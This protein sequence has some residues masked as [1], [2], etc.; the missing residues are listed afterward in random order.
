M[1]DLFEKKE[2]GVPAK[3]HHS[4]V[5]VVPPEE[6]WGPIQA[7]RE[8]HDRQFMRWMPHVNLLYPFYPPGC[9]EEAMPRLTDACAGNIPFEVQLA[10]FGYFSHP[11]GKATL[12]LAPEPREAIIRLQAALQAACPECDDL[13]RFSNGFT[14]HLSVGQ[15]GSVVEA[16]K[17]LDALQEDWQPVRFVLSAVALLRRGQDTPFEISGWIPRSI[18]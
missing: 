13:S 15:A 17:L 2:P 10:E 4:A 9:F 8:E 7:I 18:N 12:W 6:A 16:Q 5:A 14:P 11:S 1:T 3:T